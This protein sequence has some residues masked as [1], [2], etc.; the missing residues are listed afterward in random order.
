M[1]RFERIEGEKDADYIA[2]IGRQALLGNVDGQPVP[3]EVAEHLEA[4]AEPFDERLAEARIAF[5]EGKHAGADYL[6]GKV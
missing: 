2:R 1:S 5:E 6:L 4:N 3:S